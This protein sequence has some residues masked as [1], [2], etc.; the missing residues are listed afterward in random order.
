M[1]LLFNRRQLV[2]RLG[3]SFLAQQVPY[4]LV[5]VISTPHSCSLDY[6]RFLWRHCSSGDIQRASLSDSLTA[7]VCGVESIHGAAPS[8]SSV[9]LYCSPACASFSRG[10]SIRAAPFSILTCSLVDRA[11]APSCL[12]RNAHGGG[13][14]FI[15]PP[16]L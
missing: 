14:E 13:G 1:V 3:C 2:D 7:G 10:S 16:A 12:A 11:A 9:R 15:T 8:P 6:I 4:S 5:R